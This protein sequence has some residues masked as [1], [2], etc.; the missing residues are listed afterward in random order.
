MELIT[1]G[2]SRRPNMPHSSPAE[3]V[4]KTL[5]KDS[6]EDS[7]TKKYKKGTLLLLAETNKKKTE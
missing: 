3:A 4:V 2:I 1:G 5:Q 7:Q 6:A